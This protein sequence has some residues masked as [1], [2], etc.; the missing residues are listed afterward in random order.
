MNTRRK[1]LSG[2]LALAGTAGPFAAH[3]AATRGAAAAGGAPYPQ[4]AAEAAAS[5]VP[6]AYEHPPGDVRRY[7][8]TANDP[9]AASANARA[10]RALV[11]PTGTFTGKLCF[12]NASGADIYY[13]NDVIAFHDD[14]HVDLQASTLEFAKQAV[15]ADANSGFIFAVRNFSIENGSIVVKYNMGAVAPSAGSAI[16]IGN[17]GTDS[18]YFSPAYD[19]L[20]KSP[21]GNIAIRNLRITSSVPN[22]NAIEM[23]GGLVGVIIENVWIDGQS[24]LSGGIYYEFG[25][26]TPGP[27]NLRQTS[28]AHNMRFNNI[29]VTNLQTRLGAAVTLA[30]AYNCL[31]DGLYVSGAVAA[32]NGTSGESLFYRPWAGVDQ[33]GAKHTIA[34]RNVVAQGI[35]GTAL[36]LGG[37]QRAARGYLAA[38]NLTAVAQTDLGDYSVDGFVLQGGASG[39]GIY[40]SAGKADIRNGRISGFQRGIVQ[41]DDCTRLIINGVDVLECTQGGLQLDIGAAIWEPPRQKMGEIRNCVIAGNSRERAGIFPAIA[42]NNCAGFLIENNRIGYELDHDG[43]AEMTQGNAVQLGAHCI[44]VICR[45]NHVGGIYGDSVA[46]YN[47]SSNDA[48][49]NIIQSPGGILTSHGSWGGTTVGRRIVSFA[50]SI[51]I[52]ATGS[53]QFDITATSGADF[54]VNA[55]INPVINKTITVTV[56]N[57]SGGILGRVVWN[58]IFKMSPWTNPANG[59]NRSIMFRCNEGQ[60]LQVVQGGVDVPN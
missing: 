8:V 28:H 37:A 56:R 25:W 36:T 32:F 10:L 34:L 7:G 4:S 12:P 47:V 33:A 20:L 30:G 53:E 43:L 29:N 14:I 6:A 49:G 22:G 40:T 39:W 26:A 51:T 45:D 24:L 13:L 9:R 1:I 52:D 31:I 21:M 55:P 2:A 46:Y 15:A 44:N 17:R 23:T 57:A 5:I 35:S 3:A 50:S 38:R 18:T 48:R 11:A 54:V 42:L 16:H 27:T 41:G 19:S 58:A 60:W 59:H